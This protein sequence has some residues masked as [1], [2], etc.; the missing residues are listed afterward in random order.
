MKRLILSILLSTFTLALA[1]QTV[2]TL[3]IQ[4][5]LRDDQN[6]AVSDGTYQL[7]FKLYETQT[8][9]AEIWTEN[10]SL[11]ITNGVYSALL[12]DVTD[13]SGIAFNS[14]YYLGIAVDGSLELGPRIPLS[15]SPYSMAVIGS[16][17]VFPSEG[18]VGIGTTSPSDNAMLHV[19]GGNLVVSNGE[20]QLS[21]SNITLDGNWISGDGD[22][23]GIF[24]TTNGDVGIGLTN[25]A[26]R[27]EVEGNAKFDVIMSDNPYEGYDVWIQGGTTTVGG[28]SRNLALFGRDDEDIL[29][30]NYSSEYQQGTIIG[31]KT[32]ATGGFITS[33][34]QPQDIS[35][36]GRGR[37]LIEDGE[38]VGNAN[39][40][41][42]Y[43]FAGDND[44]GMFTYTDGR[45]SF[46]ADGQESIIIERG[47]IRCGAFTGYNGNNKD[48]G[49][50]DNNLFSDRRLKQDIQPYKNNSALKNIISLKPSS[51]T[52]NFVE[53][54][55]LTFGLIAQEVEQ[56]IPHAVSESGLDET[57]ADGTVIE[58]VKELDYNA[59]TIELI[60]AIRQLNN[61]VEALANEN[62]K[63]KDT[64]TN[65]AL[66]GNSFTK[67]K[68]EK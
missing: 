4:G 53:D 46:F 14:Q 54:S 7:T 43:K 40:I 10:Q 27:L 44:T 64:L 3:N 39:T 26:E 55:P 24:V 62:Q 32:L 23:E 18:T 65:L 66:S 57:L 51:F 28:D 31:G 58:N 61:K 1:A 42:G 30:V 35:G 15:L 6:K 13:L 12:G 29:Y 49:L 52:F 9:G 60:L 8:G 48:C 56:F 59:I 37:W 34:A 2:P 16:E 47:K 67:N 21:A 25:P 63:L 17:N 38:R 20:F 22:D 41:S 45:I 36:S 50:D 68:T 33:G 5:V 19:E 11:N